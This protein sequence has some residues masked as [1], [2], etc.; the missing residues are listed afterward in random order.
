MDRAPN[1]VERRRHNG[2]VHY[3]RPCRPL[4]RQSP[5]PTLSCWQAL[6]NKNFTCYKSYRFAKNSCLLALLLSK[7]PSS[8][9]S[10]RQPCALVEML[11]SL[12]SE[13]HNSGDS[14]WD[15]TIRILTC[16]PERDPPSSQQRGTPFC[17]RMHKGY[18][19]SCEGT[20]NMKIRS[21]LSHSFLINKV[22]K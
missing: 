8:A 18:V 7:D 5:Q 11:P 17:Q 19:Q 10:A 13:L 6:Y 15:T 22:E 16:A 3:L 1:T 2:I 12:L 14:S 9:T 21:S 4:V 20:P